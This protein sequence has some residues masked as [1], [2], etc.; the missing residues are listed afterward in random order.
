VIYNSN[1]PAS[2]AAQDLQARSTRSARAHRNVDSASDAR[3]AR[4]PVASP[5]PANE[6][7][8]SPSVKT[9]SVSD[10]NFTAALS[11]IEDQVQASAATQHARVLIQTQPSAAMVAQ[12]NAPSQSA[13]RLL[14]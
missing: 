4:S 3:K 11:A 8:Q 7:R 14:Q 9:P 5:E 2:A 1:I 6:S 12:A 13:L 10:I